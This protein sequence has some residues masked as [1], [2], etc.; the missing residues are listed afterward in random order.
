MTPLFPNDNEKITIKQ[1]QTGDC[2]LLAVLDCVLNSGDEGRE[3]IES[4]FT[5]NPDE[6][7]TLRIPHNDHSRYLILRG[8]NDKYQYTYNAATK[9][10]EITISKAELE[11]ID[12]NKI[13]ANTRGVSSNSLAVKILEH[14]SSYYYAN[15][16][17]QAHSIIAHNQDDRYWGNEAAVFVSDLLGIKGNYTKDCD[18]IIKLK[19]INP[20]HPLY[21]EMDYGTPDAF[22][23]IHGYHALRIK[24]IVQNGASYDFVLANPWD[25]RKGE[26][27]SL[28]EI[29]KRHYKFCE[30]NFD[31]PRE[32]LNKSILQCSEEVGEYIY[33][34]P[35]LMT[36]LLA[37]YKRGWGSLYTADNLKSCV[38]IHQQI[39]YF[40]LLLDVLTPDDQQVMLRR[41]FSAQGSK[42]EFIKQLLIRLPNAQLLQKLLKQETNYE[43][44]GNILVNLATSADNDARQ[45]RSLLT[46][47]A[48]FNQVVTTAIQHKAQQP[49][50]QGLPYGQKDATDFV[51]EGLINHFFKLRGERYYLVTRNAGLR[52]LCSANVFTEAHILSRIAPELL[53][54][55]AISQVMKNPIQSPEVKK[56]IEN[57]PAVTINEAFLDKV[58]G[59]VTNQD[60]YQLFNGLEKLNTLDAKLA[61]ELFPLLAARTDRTAAGSFKRLAQE[62]A[63]KPSSAFKAWFIQMQTDLLPHTVEEDSRKQREEEQARAQQLEKIKHNAQNVINEYALAIYDAPIPSFQHHEKIVEIDEEQGN[64]IRQLNNKVMNQY[65]L[66]QAQQVL[67]YDTLTLPTAVKNALDAKVQEVKQAAMLAKQKIMVRNEGTVLLETINF[68]AQLDIIEKMTM[69]LEEK[70]KSD[71]NYIRAA[72]SA[73]TLHNQLQAAK[74]SLLTSELPKNKNILQFKNLCIDAIDDANLVLE[75]H[76]G[77]KE[78]LEIIASALVSIV[79]LLTANMAAGRWRLFSTPTH[80]AIITNEIKEVFNDITVSA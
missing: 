68:A 65:R 37:M 27:F 21:V 3:L 41:M 60:P 52:A 66:R 55:T 32:E 80:S 47:Q 54:A 70:A 24:R 22:G 51:E 71:D 48:M 42:G 67:G 45:V 12:E 7:V 11:R 5:K 39:P 16:W 36:L 33:K 76:R 20:T 73:R 8:I 59:K 17:D 31:A 34:T 25:N 53:L 6:S 72:H 75:E 29:K 69:E 49:N 35:E 13:G 23:K 44:I 19:A 10:D 18:K 56:F 9:T 14:I 26:T 46:T 4:M 58:L 63:S 57:H 15:A 78:V 30:L 61:K 1:G 38:Q 28:D 62:V 40:Q 77:W 2:Y 79:T 64:Q 50:D 74:E 43:Q